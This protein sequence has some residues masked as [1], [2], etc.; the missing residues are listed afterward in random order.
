MANSKAGFNYYNVD[1]DRYQDIRIKRLKKELGCAGIAIYDYMLCETY[2]VRGYYLE[3]DVNVCFDIAEYLQESE[4]YIFHVLQKCLKIGLFDLSMFRRH[5][6]VTSKSIQE[7][8]I[9]MCNWSKRKDKSVTEKYNL[10]KK[11]TKIPVIIKEKVGVSPE[12]NNPEDKVSEDAFMEEF[13]SFRKKYHGS[14]RGI[15]T[16]FENFKKKHSD[17]KEVVFLLNPAL[18][19]LRTWRDL[20]RA[21]GQ[22]V[23]EYAN[24]STWIN[25]RRW[26]VEHEKITPNG[27]YRKD[28]ESEQRK[29]HI[30]TEAARISTAN[31]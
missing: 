30:S 16:E 4:E 14:K 10:I 15:I 3:W 11:A 1:T 27:T 28:T 8:Y 2:R 24:L 13:E 26:E 29:H 12:G 25:Q 22:F 17:Y 9:Q 20:K 23:P 21:E 18:K 7:R 19:A 6:V 31:A 5:K